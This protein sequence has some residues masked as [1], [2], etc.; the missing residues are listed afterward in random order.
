MTYSTRYLSFSN[1]DTE[2]PIVAFCSVC[3]RRFE[4][5]QETGKRIDDLILKV[6]AEFDAHGCNSAR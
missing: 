1:L 4:V 6:R 3:G 5:Q 2:Q